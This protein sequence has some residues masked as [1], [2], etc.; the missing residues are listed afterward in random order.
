MVEVKYYELDVSSESELELK[1]GRQIID[2]EPS[3]TVSTT[4][5]VQPDELDDP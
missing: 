2:V 5:K 3:A 4:T 1:K